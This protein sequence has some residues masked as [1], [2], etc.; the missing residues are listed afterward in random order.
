MVFIVQQEPTPNES[1]VKLSVITL[2]FERRNQTKTL[3]IINRKCS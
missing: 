2:A 3:N 1:S